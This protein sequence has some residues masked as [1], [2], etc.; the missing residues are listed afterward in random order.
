MT[1]LNH[2][3]RIAL[4]LVVVQTCCG[5]GQLMSPF[6]ASDPHATGTWTGR[7]LS[8]AVQDYDGRQYRAAA[9]DIA[10]GPRTL[11]GSSGTIH[12]TEGHDVVLLS[13]VGVAIADPAEL[14]VPVGSTVKVSG[15]LISAGAVKFFQTAPSGGIAEHVIP[16][17]PEVNGG[18]VLKLRGHAKKVT[19]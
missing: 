13:S 3:V 14:S 9:L 19:E 16:S 10:T 8:V 4:L 7:L 17:S 6:G 18:L 1:W 15:T 12:L 11:R 2:A 5:C